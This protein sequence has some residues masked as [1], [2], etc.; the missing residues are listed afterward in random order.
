MIIIANE[1]EIKVMKTLEL[2]K[3]MIDCQFIIFD[4][5]KEITDYWRYGKDTPKYFREDCKKLF[6]IDI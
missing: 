3:L 5:V 1:F 6:D 2:L 4:K